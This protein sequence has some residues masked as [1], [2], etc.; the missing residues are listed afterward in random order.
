MRGIQYVVNDKGRVSA[1]LIDLKK[2]GRL[3]EDFQ[4]MLLSHAR[5]KERRHTLADVEACVRKRRNNR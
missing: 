4:D 2:R 1:V 5:R 3:W